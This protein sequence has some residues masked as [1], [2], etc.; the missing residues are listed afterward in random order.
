VSGISLQAGEGSGGPGGDNL[1]LR[2]FGARNDFFVDGIRDFGGYSRD[3]FNLEQ[4]E[5]VKG[6]ASAN[7]GR[8]STGG[9]INL[10]SKQA[11]LDDNFTRVN[12]SARSHELFRTTIDTNHEIE[13]IE[14]A[15]L[16]V[17]ILAHDQDIPGRDYVYNNRYGVDTSLAFGLDEGSDTR[18]FLNLFY[19]K[20]DNLSDYGI[21]FV[22]NNATG[23][24]LFPGHVGLPAP[25]NYDNFYGLVDRDFEDTDVA[26]FTARFEH[27]INEAVT[28]R[29]Q[30]RI[31]RSNRF[32]LATAPRFNA[33]NPGVITR[34]FQDRDEVIDLFISQ[35]DL[36]F[37]FDTGV[38]E[39]GNMRLFWEWKL[40]GKTTSGDA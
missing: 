6:P 27:D 22:E 30:T 18:L 1:T 7:S 40:P 26:R 32:S 35:S 19:Q 37:K 2:G 10:A 9:Y 17:N 12:V 13:Q 28:I 34:N 15:A 24:G 38:P 5:V 8:G 23:V 36:L 4:I 16:R 21:P 39:T 31:G 33:A 3:P 20:E 11:R 29:N 25:V 14:G